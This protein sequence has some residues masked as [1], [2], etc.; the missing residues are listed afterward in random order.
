MV[1]NRCRQLIVLHEQGD[2]KTFVENGIVYF[3]CKTSLKS[4]HRFFIICIFHELYEE[5]YIHMAIFCLIINTYHRNKICDEIQ[6]A[7]KN[8]S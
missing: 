8:E 7:M 5:R 4:A 3:W 2:F 6:N 1:R